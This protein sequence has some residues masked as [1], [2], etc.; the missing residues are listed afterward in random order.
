MAEAGERR[1]AA[2]AIVLPEAFVPGPAT[3]VVVRL[4]DV[5]RADAPAVIVAEVILRPAAGRPL[6]RLP[7]ELTGPPPPRGRHALRVHVDVD[8][9]GH[10]DAGDFIGVVTPATPGEAAHGLLIGVRRVS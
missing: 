10:I 7:F 6:A 5:S 1:L 9:S 8:G 3:R 4:E 2:G